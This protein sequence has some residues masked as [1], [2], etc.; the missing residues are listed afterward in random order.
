MYAVGVEGTVQLVLGSGSYV[1]LGIGRVVAIV[2]V[3]G[4]W[5]TSRVRGN[6]RVGFDTFWQARVLG[7]AAVR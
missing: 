1:L 2:P 5:C 4:V 7:Y 6:G 3:E